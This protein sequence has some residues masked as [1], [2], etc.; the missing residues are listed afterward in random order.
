MTTETTALIA[1]GSNLGDRRANLELALTA[2]AEIPEVRVTAVSSIHETSPVGGPE[3]QGAFL[4]AAA[5]LET[6]LD[7][8]PLLD[9]LNA[10]EAKA[11]RVR[12]VRWGSRTL[13]LD[14]ILFGSSII[15]T[16]RLTVPHP[17][18]A[19][20]RF[21]L[22]PAREVAPV[23]LD[24]VTNLS[25]QQLLENVDRRPSLVALHGEDGPFLH[26]VFT[27]LAAALDDLQGESS[28]PND[29]WLVT[30]APL[31]RSLPSHVLS[32]PLTVVDPIR[33][34]SPP[35]H[36]SQRPTFMVILN[37]ASVDV[38]RVADRGV[39]RLVV[40]SSDPEAAVAEI[41]AACTATRS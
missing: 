21:V 28:I 36:P 31:S 8:E 10:I 17:R 6:T 23:A 25:I 30:A 24:P 34:F 27:R 33:T 12:R 11:K 5:T 41:R 22:A 19:L 38:T 2:L 37:P 1:L 15:R 14:L 35:A 4:N 32:P 29:R 16:S 7:S 39:P 9:V 18:M 20:R 13:D 40:T 26:A 3:G